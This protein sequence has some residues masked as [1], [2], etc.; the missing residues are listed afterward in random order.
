MRNLLFVLLITTF[1]GNAQ[2][3]LTIEADGIQSSD[4][5]IGVGVYDTEKTFLKK[6]MTFAGAFAV[7]QKGKTLITIKDL[8]E[9]TYAI[10]IFHD[11]NGNKVLDTNFIGI[12]MEPV[13]FSKAKMKTF[14]PPDFKACSFNLTSDYQINI[15]IK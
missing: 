12:P 4:G 13:A 10:S 7:T 3:T 6:E 5:Y 9:G 1:F 15:P 11:K 2:H 14:G 8:P